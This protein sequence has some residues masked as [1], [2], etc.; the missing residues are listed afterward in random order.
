[1]EQADSTGGQQPVS[2]GVKR[3]ARTAEL[4][5]EDEQYKLKD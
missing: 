4:P 1:M 5:D 3:D 2:S